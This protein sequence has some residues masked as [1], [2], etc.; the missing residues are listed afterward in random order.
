MGFRSKAR[1]DPGAAPMQ[2]VAGP[3]TDAQIIDL[4]AFVGSRRPW[5]RAEM[6][7]AMNG[8]RVEPQNSRR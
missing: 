6:E 5:T 8:E 2:E 3:L 7:K 4:A 1:N